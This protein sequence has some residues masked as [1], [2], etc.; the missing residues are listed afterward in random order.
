ML[1]RLQIYKF[2]CYELKEY[3][4]AGILNFIKDSRLPDHVPERI[5]TAGLPLRS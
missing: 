4:K 1:S 2:V 3:K 5:R